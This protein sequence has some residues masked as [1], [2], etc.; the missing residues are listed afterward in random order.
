MTFLP[1][2]ARELR[3][4]SRRRG[5][6]WTRTVVA[7]GAIGIGV[8]FYLANIEAPPLSLRTEFFRA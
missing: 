4:A 8:F 1:I 6:F 2:V 7:L 3:V 5:T